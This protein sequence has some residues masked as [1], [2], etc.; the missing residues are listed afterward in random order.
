MFTSDYSAQSLDS[1]IALLIA[2]HAREQAHLDATRVTVKVVGSLDGSKPKGK[3][4][5]A[6]RDREFTSDGQRSADASKPAPPSLILPET[7]S[8]TAREFLLVL[9]T[10][11]R[12]V[13]VH[14][15]SF[16]DEREV[17]NDTIKAIAGYVGWDATRS[18]GSQDSEART[19]A[20]REIA[21]NKRLGG[22]SVQES[23]SAARSLAGFT[24]AAFGK[25]DLTA[26]HLANLNAQLVAAT[27]AMC[28]Y[29]RAGNTAGETVERM[30]LDTLHAE[31]ASLV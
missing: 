7:G 5:K 13:S 8:L 20:G 31:I 18:F 30:R 3:G 28:E 25:P 21:G 22:L 24:S 17:R 14:G 6:K 15:T 4:L 2:Q 29:V 23:R 27:E 12:R 26:K 11:G 9:R 10:C 19:K 16:T 1:A